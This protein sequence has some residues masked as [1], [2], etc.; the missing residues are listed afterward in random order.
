MPTVKKEKEILADLENARYITSSLRD[1]SA[2]ELKHYRKRFDRNERF[3]DDM[4]RLS[5]VVRSIAEERGLPQVRVRKGPQVHVAFTTNSSFYG[6]LNN[7]V[8]RNLEQHVG[9]D[10]HVLIVGET[11]KGYWRNRRKQHKHVD[12]M[13]FAEDN[14]SE[15]E[16]REFLERVSRYKNVFIHYPGFESV[17]KQDARMLDITYNT[18][19]GQAEADG[20]PEL[21]YILEPEI[22]DMFFFFEVQVRFV[23]FERVL[24]ETNLS[25]VAARLMKTDTAEQNATDLIRTQHMAIRRARARTSSIRMLE[26]FTGYLQWKK[27]QQ[28]V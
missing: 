18:L 25:R 6:S 12:S 26:T 22:I 14:P 21:K 9:G 24:L 16:V 11:G 27:E 8:M 1:I 5:H 20:V 7:D 2:V 19:K 10:D 23:L 15:S 3:Y 28:N 4:R 13:V 17:F